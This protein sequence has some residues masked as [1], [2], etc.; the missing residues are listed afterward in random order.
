MVGAVLGFQKREGQLL[1][2]VTIQTACMLE[3]VVGSCRMVTTCHGRFSIERRSREKDLYGQRG[4][5]LGL[6]WA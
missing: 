1:A 2:M 3:K 4:G 6:S 5:Y